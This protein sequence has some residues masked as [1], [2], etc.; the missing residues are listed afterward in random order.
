MLTCR[1]D[2]S[3]EGVMSIHRD[4][5]YVT[6]SRSS[7]NIEALASQ[8]KQQLNIVKTQDSKKYGGC[9][10]TIVA[11]NE[12]GKFD[13]NSFPATIVKQM[14]WQE[15]VKQQQKINVDVVSSIVQY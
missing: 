10:L 13:V 14:M 8:V 12:F 3:F 5:G 4:T 9:E 6:R 2:P 7:R 15:C 1:D 11:G